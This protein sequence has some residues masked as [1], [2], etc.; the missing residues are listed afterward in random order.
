[1][2]LCKTWTSH[3]FSS[4]SLNCCKNNTIGHCDLKIC[5]GEDMKLDFPWLV[6]CMLKVDRPQKRSFE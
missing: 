5:T 1:M 4:P 3:N 2:L 6:S